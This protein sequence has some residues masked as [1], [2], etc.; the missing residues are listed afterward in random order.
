MPTQLKP[1]NYFWNVTD[2]VLINSRDLVND[3]IVARDK[4]IKELSDA[5]SPI[6]LD[7]IKVDENG[8]VVITDATFNAEIKAKIQAGH[9]PTTNINGCRTS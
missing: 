1:E 7:Q 5:V 6:R 2:K 3:L 4:S 8:N 9:L